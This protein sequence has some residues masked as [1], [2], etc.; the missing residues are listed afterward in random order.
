MKKRSRL[1]VKKKSGGLIFFSFVC[2]SLFPFPR[3][4]FSKQQ[5]RKQN[6]VLV[7]AS[8]RILSSILGVGFFSFYTEMILLSYII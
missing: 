2:C 6:G 5:L 3:E 7:S 8:E 4:K 1:S